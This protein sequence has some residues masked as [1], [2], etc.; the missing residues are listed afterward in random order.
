MFRKQFE[1]AVSR[2]RRDIPRPARRDSIKAQLRRVTLKAEALRK[3]LTDLDPAAQYAFGLYAARQSLFGMAKDADES[4]FQL[5][6]MVEIGYGSP[7]QNLNMPIS[8]KWWSRSKMRQNPIVAEKLK[9][10]RPG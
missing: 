1:E 10:G 8:K 7:I 6:D 3:V 4:R 9:R 2:A 5:N